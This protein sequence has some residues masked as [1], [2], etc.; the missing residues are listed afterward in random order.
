MFST[1]LRSSPDLTVLRVWPTVAAGE[2]ITE[3]EV[4]AQRPAGHEPGAILWVRERTR[5]VDD[6]KIDYGGDHNLFLRSEQWRPPSA[7]PRRLARMFLRVLSVCLAYEG[8]PTPQHRPSWFWETRVEVVRD[9]KGKIC[10][11]GPEAVWRAGFHAAMT[12]DDLRAEQVARET[13]APLIVGA[14]WAALRE[15]LFTFASTW[16]RSVHHGLLVTRSVIAL[17]KPHKKHVGDAWAALVE[18]ERVERKGARF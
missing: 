12:Y 1:A 11:P 6:G 17:V 5:T 9:R 10:P 8:Y 7:M 4:L 18:K 3:A 2:H 13:L 14:E 15:H 16:M